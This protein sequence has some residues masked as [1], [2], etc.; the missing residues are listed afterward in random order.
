MNSPEDLFKNAFENFESTPPDDLWENINREVAFKSFFRFYPKRLNI[1]Y[2]A[3]ALAV[4]S[5]ALYYSFANSDNAP[6]TI[7]NVEQSS[8]EIIASQRKVLIQDSP[9]TFNGGSKSPSEN[10]HIQIVDNN[11][12][13]EVVTDNNYQPDFSNRPSTPSQSVDD[14]SAVEPE[15]DFSA[16]FTAE[17]LNPCTPS[18]VRFVNHSKDV[19]YCIWN[20]G[21]G[22]TSYDY[23]ATVNYRAAGTYY[24]TLKTV[25]GTKSKVSAQTVVVNP[26]PSA[27]ISHTKALINMPMIVEARNTENVSHIK[28][29]FG[30]ETT[31]VSSKAAHKYK[32]AGSYTLSLI[33]SNQYCTDTITETIEVAVPEYSLWFPNALYASSSGATDGFGG[34]SP[35][36]SP[37]LPQGDVNMI[38]RYNLRIFSKTGK[39]VFSSTDPAFG[40]NGYFHGRKLSSG[41]YV[42]KVVYTFVNGEYYTS[43]GNITLIYGE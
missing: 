13:S 17:I 36:F 18:V 41:V 43:E 27:S 33:V 5:T 12:Y 37:F 1:Y 10:S 19:D 29:L 24:V 23:N 7:S 21:N 20:F 22:T 9:V 4:L 39:E 15:S 38:D 30:D 3:A 28:W 40:W 25:K 14:P 26:T 34:G 31:S 6:I 16:D 8:K 42:Y 32:N 11:I 35:K 2:M